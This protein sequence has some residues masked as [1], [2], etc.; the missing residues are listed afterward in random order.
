MGFNSPNGSTMKTSS[1]CVVCNEID[2]A[3]K[4]SRHGECQNCYADRKSCD[5]TVIEILMNIQAESDEDGDDQ[6]DD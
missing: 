3:P 4:L 2:P 6:F 5:W 1:R